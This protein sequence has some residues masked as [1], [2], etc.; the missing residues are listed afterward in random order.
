WRLSIPSIAIAELRPSLLQK[1]GEKLGPMTPLVV[2]NLSL[3]GLEGELEKSHTWTAVGDLKFINSF[4]REYTLADIPSDV[5]SRIFGLDLELLIP[6]RGQCKFALE[7]GLFR[8]KELEQ[9]YS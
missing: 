9:A 4:K 3:R 6:V 2:R 7:G 8:L 1:W 5:L